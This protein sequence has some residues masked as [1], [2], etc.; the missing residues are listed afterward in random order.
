MCCF[1]TGIARKAEKG[2]RGCKGLPGWFGALF[3]TFARLTE[4][5]DLK[6]FWQCPNRTN[7]LQ[8]GASRTLWPFF[9]TI[10]SFIYYHR[11]YHETE[12]GMLSPAIRLEPN[13]PDMNFCLALCTGRQ[14][15]FLTV[16]DYLF[17][18]P[19]SD[20]WLCLSLTDSLTP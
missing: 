11:K 16:S 19:E 7:T 13:V 1:H 2:G 8:K 18:G 6:L 5:G 9:L 14:D 12:C 10:L 4:G 15:P 3:S 17:I 20:H